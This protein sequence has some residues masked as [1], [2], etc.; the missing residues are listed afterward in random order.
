[1]D[2]AIVFGLDEVSELLDSGSEALGTILDQANE[3]F[4]KVFKQADLVISKGA[5]KLR[6][7]VRL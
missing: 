6:R 7:F 5:G 4:L 1:M 2:D 3:K